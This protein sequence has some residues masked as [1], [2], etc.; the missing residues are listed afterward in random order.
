MNWFGLLATLSKRAQWKRDVIRVACILP[1]G[2]RYKQVEA[3]CKQ[4]EVSP[5]DISACLLAQEDTFTLQRFYEAL[6]RRLVRIDASRQQ[7]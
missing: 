3:A 5:L 7:D 6:P 4:A 2:Y 1:G